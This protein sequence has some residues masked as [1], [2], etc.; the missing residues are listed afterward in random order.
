VDDQERLHPLA[1]VYRRS[2]CWELVRALQRGERSLH[3]ALKSQG[4]ATR[5]VHVNQFC[6]DDPELLSL[7]NCNTPEEYESAMQRAASLSTH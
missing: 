7:V 1:A 3:R 4:V 2:V 6:G 5:L